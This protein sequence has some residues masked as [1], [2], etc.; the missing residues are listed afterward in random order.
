M[1]IEH[2]S[3]LINIVEY[4]KMDTTDTVDQMIFQWWLNIKQYRNK[5][6]YIKRQYIFNEQ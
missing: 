5:R 1:N 2:V 3:K 6:G 4:F